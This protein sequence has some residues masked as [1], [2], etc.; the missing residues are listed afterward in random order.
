MLKKSILM[1]SRG[2]T[3]FCYERQ[4]QKG[5][6]QKI[7]ICLEMGVSED[8]LAKYMEREKHEAE[9]RKS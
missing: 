2:F 5:Y 6:I 8:M 9:W 1:K 3:L 7:I 4:N